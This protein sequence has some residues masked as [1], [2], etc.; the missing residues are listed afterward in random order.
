MVLNQTIESIK[1]NAPLD[2]GSHRINLVTTEDYKTL[3]RQLF[4]NTQGVA[5]FG[6]ESGSFDTSVGVTSTPE[7]GKVFISI[8]STTGQ[9][10]TETQKEQLKTDL[11]EYTV[12]SIT[13]VIVDP[14]T[15]SHIDF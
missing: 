9:T 4:A 10:L 12:A 14:E 6:G 1:L 2:Y 15:I 8:K 7:F 13:P 11:Q 5:V 3:V